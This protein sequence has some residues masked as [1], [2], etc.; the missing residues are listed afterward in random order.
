MKNTKY[1][2][3]IGA[4]IVV[5]GLVIGGLA[6]KKNQ[7]PS[8]SSAAPN[9]QQAATSNAITIKSYAFSPATVTVK[10][11]TTV[12]WTN[13]DAVAHTVT[14]DQ[15]SSDKFDSGN[16]QQNGTYSYTFTN[17]GTFTY[18]CTPHPSMQARVIV[19]N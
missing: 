16:I 4:I 19:T 3:I 2:W 9:S 14:S 18:H 10:A 7:Q 13:M 1:I 5:G 11:G 17:P 8:G 12:T 6:A 15:G